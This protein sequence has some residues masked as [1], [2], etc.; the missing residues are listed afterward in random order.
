MKPKIY[1]L[2]GLAADRRI[3]LEFEFQHADF[4]VIEWELP[5]DPK[6]GFKEYA[7]QLSQHIPSGTNHYLC[8]VSLG[9]M[10]AQEMA[11]FTQPIRTFVIS[12]IKRSQPLPLLIEG[13]RKVRLNEWMHWKQVKKLPIAVKPLLSNSIQR[14]LVPKMLTDSDSD[15]S[16]WAVQQILNRNVS[17]DISNCMVIHGTSDKVFPYD[18]SVTDLTIPKGNHFMVMGQGKEIS[19]W[20][21]QKIAQDEVDIRE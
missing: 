14:D 11:L 6:M 12:S 9:G 21:D 2:P 7:E 10:I 20:M 18:E 8:G 5:K 1:A 15:F 13:I 19:Q 17:S 3:Y 4:E 16:D